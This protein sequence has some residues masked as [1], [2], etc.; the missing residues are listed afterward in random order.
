MA[1]VSAHQQ[2]DDYLKSL[3]SLAAVANEDDMTD[4]LYMDFA[5]HDRPF[6]VNEAAIEFIPH[7]LMG[8]ESLTPLSTPSTTGAQ[9]PLFDR[10]ADEE[11]VLSDFLPFDSD[12]DLE[13]PPSPPTGQRR[14]RGATSL[15]EDDFEFPVFLGRQSMDG[16]EDSSSSRRSRPVPSGPMRPMLP[17][18]APITTA[19]TAKAATTAKAAAAP[20][21]PELSGPMM[22]WWPAPVES[23]QY[24]WVETAAAPSKTRVPVDAHVADLEGP[25][26]SWW[27]APTELMEYEWQ[28]RFYE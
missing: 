24:D 5:K 16:E 1:F 14:H 26:M 3:A 11:A 28:E 9:T 17:R 22:A 23:L 18:A 19:A 6:I 15:G 27:P 4:M 2:Q 25:L 8:P 7:H 10:A 20:A 21:V 13:I 12:S